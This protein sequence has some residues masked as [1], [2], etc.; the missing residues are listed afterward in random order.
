MSGFAVPAL[1]AWTFH[2]WTN[3]RL[4]LSGFELNWDYDI[5][6]I[7]LDAIDLGIKPLSL[8]YDDDVSNGANFNIVGYPGDKPWLTRWHQFCPWEV[9]SSEII[10]TKTCDIT[11]GSSGSPVYRLSSTTF[12]RTVQCIVSWEN[13]VYNGCA[14]LTPSKIAS[15]CSSIGDDCGQSGDV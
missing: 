4:T 7:E 14:R 12:E 1:Q 5:A 11:G 2:Q 15:I 6:W 8:G 9:V 3:G 13:T 10:F